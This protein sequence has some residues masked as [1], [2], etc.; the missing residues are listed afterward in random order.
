MSTKRRGAGEGGISAYTTAAGERHSIVYRV[1]DP[2]RGKTRQ[3]RERGFTT[4]RAAQTALRE[5]V[6][7]VEAQS[8]VA[9]S[10]LTVREFIEE[11][12]LPSLRSQVR[13]STYDSYERNLRLH[14]LPRIGGLALRQLDASRLSAAYAD[15]LSTGRQDHL[16]GTA[17]SARSVRYI[18]T[19][20]GRAL[21]TAQAWDLVTRNAAT[22]AV[23]PRVSAAGDRHEGINTWTH[24]E[25]G[26]FLAATRAERLFPLWLLLGTTGLR[27]GEAIGIAWEAVDLDAARLS[28]RRSLVD[29]TPDHAGSAPVFSD[30]KTSAGRRSVALDPATVEVLR[31]LR[32]AQAAERLLVG[33]GYRE[34]GLV[35]AHPDG[36]PLHPERLS[37]S[38]ADTMRRHAARAIRLHDLRH[39]WATLALEAGVHPK[40]VQE[41]LGH[42]NITITLQTYSHVSPAMQTDAADRVAAL[43]LGGGA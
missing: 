29:V 19:I 24:Q 43:I 20:I 14:V 27:R 18:H 5:R 37:R 21:K 28:V 8:Y 38:F 40:V 7:A 41:R 33:P 4:K 12:Y 22:S 34:H 11:R 36:R 30:P 26:A 15:L 10:K 3:V 32:K 1:P 31:G 2:A 17:L 39:T 13:A 42:S 16:A 9:P 23:V 35:F 6:A 25:L